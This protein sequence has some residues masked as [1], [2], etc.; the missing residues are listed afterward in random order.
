MP[1]T[2]QIQNGADKTYDFTPVDYDIGHVPPRCGAGRY[3]AS[4]AVSSKGTNAEKLP[5]LVVE[6]TV[7]AVIDGNTENEQFIGATVTDYLVLRPETDVKGRMHKLRLRQLLDRMGL[8]YELVPR[9]IETKGDLE[10]LCA[11]VSG[12]RM[13][14]TVSHRDD[15]NTGETRENI[16]YAEPRGGSDG[17]SADAEVEPQHAAPARQAARP[18]ARP[19]A[20][21]AAKTANRRG[22]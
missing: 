19:A 15:P 13:T 4:C 6:W 5:M 14:I 21:P 22:R 20:K 9:R 12:Q 2:Q 18:A 17:A 10:E 8:S 16:S 11:A 7:E 1:A 3:E